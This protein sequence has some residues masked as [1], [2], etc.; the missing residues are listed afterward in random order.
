MTGI[1]R[2]G[3][4]AAQTGTGHGR[5]RTMRA[6]WSG[7][8][9][10]S[11][12]AAMVTSILTQ[13]TYAGGKC[14]PLIAL[15]VNDSSGADPA[16]LITN[17]TLLLDRLEAGGVDRIFAST[18]LRP[19]SSKNGSYTGGRTYDASVGALMRL[20]RQRGVNVIPVGLDW[21]AEGLF[22]D[23]I[24]PGDPGNMRLA[25]VVIE[26]LAGNP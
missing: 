24:H 4:K 15:G 5:L 22:T 17:A 6:A 1:V 25:Q 26:A 11:F 20:Y 21:A 7:Y 3:V 10:G 14:T 23:G 19:A 9:F 13:A 18:P 2:L 8:T 16:T 12:S